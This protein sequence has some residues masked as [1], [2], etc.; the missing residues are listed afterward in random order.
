MKA[1]SWIL[2]DGVQMIFSIVLCVHIT[3]TTFASGL[4]FENREN[5]A[6]TF[7][8][9][10]NSTWD[11]STANFFIREIAKYNLTSLYNTSYSY[12]Y[13]LD[14]SIK[15]LVPDTYRVVADL[16]GQKCTGDVFYRG[17]DISDV[18]IPEM[19]DLKLILVCGNSY[20]E[21]RDFR[22]IA[23]DPVTGCRIEFDYDV[24]DETKKYSIKIEDIRFHSTTE[25][26][27]QFNKRINQIDCYFAAAQ[28]IENAIHEINQANVGRNN[29]IESYFRIRELERIYETVSAEYFIVELDIPHNDIAG[30]FQKLTNFKNQLARFTQYFSFILNTANSVCINKSINY[31]AG[32]FADESAKNILLS[33]TVSHTL[34]GYFKK[35]GLITYSPSDIKRYKR[36]LREIILKTRFAEYSDH[37]VNDFISEVFNVFILNASNLINDQNYIAALGVLNNAKAFY[38]ATRGRNLPVEHIIL[39]S[40]ANYGIYDSY[41]KIINKAFELENFELAENYIVKALAFQKENRSSIISDHYLT[42]VSQKLIGF[43]IEKGNRLNEDGEF[44][45]AIGCFDHARGISKKINRY[46][47]KYEIDH[48]LICARNGYYRNLLEQARTN[49]ES[50]NYLQAKLLIHKASDL[51]EANPGQITALSAHNSLMSFINQYTY[52]E[53]MEEGKLLLE[54]GN[55]HFAYEKL[56]AAADLHDRSGFEFDFELASLFK[57]SAMPVLI[58]LCDIAEVKVRK[59]QLDDARHIYDQCLQLQSEYGLAYEGILQE[60]LTRLNNQIFEKQCE[61]NSLEFNK[62]IETFWIHV[63]IGD[64]ISAVEILT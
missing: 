19:V 55:Y 28:V 10:E 42:G 24:A 2:R 63:K 33:Q 53:L 50:G 56:L 36:E 4:V 21:T 7:S 39:T 48:G 41:L 17:F 5:N 29:L 43:Y 6:Y 38:H 12:H 9:S 11:N 18:L 34:S 14:N 30:F 22:R 37:L 40:R 54:S 61:Y 47:F 35:L 57:V 59:D 27:V 31:Y 52:C 3:N 58:N 62:V 8:Y 64:Y 13:S 16:K 23:L 25:A 32:I 20:I 46:N 26:Q 51:F 15:S 45:S 44:E 49:V 60:Q 1:G